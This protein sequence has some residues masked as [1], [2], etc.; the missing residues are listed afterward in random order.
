MMKH[1]LLYTL[2]ILFSSLSFTFAQEGTIRGTIK[3]AVSKEDLVGAT[4]FIEGINK[5]A[6]ADINGFFSFNK[7]PVGSYKLKISFVGYKVK[8]IENVKVVEGS[9]TEINT[10]I[11]EDQATTLNEVRVVA[12]KL[13]N[14]EVSVISEI[15]AAQ[16][17]VSGISAAQIGKTLDRTAA[18]VVKRVPGVTIFGDRFIN[19]RGLNERYNTVMLNNVFT[20]SMESDVRSFSFDVIPSGQID[21]ILVYKSPAAELPGEFA[22]GVVKIFTKSI[23][24]ENY[25]TI[26]VSGAYRDGTTG[27]EFFRPKTGKYSYTG[28]NN[29]YSDLPKFF[30]ST[31]ELKQIAVSNQAALAQAG[32]MLRNTWTPEASTASPDLRFSITGAYKFIDKEN[33]KL[34]NITAVNYSNTRTTFEMARS[35]FGYSIDQNN[36]ESINEDTKFRDLQYNNSVRTGILHNW[37]LR[38]NENH[39]FEFKNLYNQMSNAQYVNRNGLENGG[40][41]NIRSLDQ[42]YRGIYTGQVLGRHAFNDNK[43]KLDWVV[44]YNKSNS[45]RPDYK[46]YRYSTEGATPALLVPF[47]AAQTVNLGRTNIVLD[48]D[49]ILGGINLVQKLTIVKGKTAEES[50]EIELKAGVFYENKKRTFNARNLGYVRA[51]SSLFDIG[52]LPIDEIFALQNI[53]TTNG[54]K[55]DE[56]TNASDSYTASNNQIAGYVSGN[57]SFTKKLNL[58]AGVR[59]EKNVQKLNSYDISRNAPVN[60]NRDLTNILP[61]ANLTYNFSEKALLRLA[62][63]KT[64]NRPE[65]REVAPFS[66]YDFVNNRVITGSPTLNNA[67]IDNYDFRYEFYP[68]PAEVIS[69]AAFYKNFKNPIEVIFDGVN[70]AN[71]SFGNAESA[72]SAGF[73]VEVKKSLDKLT[74]SALLSKINLVFNG[75][76]IY[77]RVKI[78]SS[79]QN[80]SDNRPL[81]GQSPYIINAGI[82]YN[83]AKKNTQ[84]SLLFNVIGKRIYAVGNSFAAGYPDW[85]EMPRNVVDFTFSKEIARNLILKGGITDI[86]NQRNLIIQDGNK[87]N[88][89]NA[90]VDQVIQSYS[91]GRTYS[92]GLV[93]TL[94]KK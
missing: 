20:P 82:N 44:G 66:F 56:Q 85:Y 47:G 79:A 12:K 45:D 5:G 61:S 10:F 89:Y 60:Y 16:Q 35:D 59:V 92:L 23:P 31:D 52:S 8:F 94:R 50:K 72:Y 57:Y 38:L 14:T 54:I 68:T 24:D 33:L 41:W 40:T 2:I 19:I 28:F 37:A 48:E 21:R 76:F 43:T 65:F 63:G 6:A 58:I 29:G 62:Y 53:N 46:R 18:E 26:D 1:K 81:Q 83:D 75:A 73:E 42:V 84:I 93:Y 91:P 3:D 64:L 22:G 87:D 86:L 9:V 27:N 17:I 36:V 25:L 15:K 32:Q 78:G 34:A 67:D 49:A 70:N 7:I 11:E 69:V 55:I 77:S 71:L 80:Q 4:V 51:N 13:T 88:T 30:P 74:A 90:N 39:T